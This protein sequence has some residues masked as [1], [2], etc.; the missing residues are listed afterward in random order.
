LARVEPARRFFCRDG[1]L[2]TNVFDIQQAIAI[3]FMIKYEK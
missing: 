2:L 3:M 1:L